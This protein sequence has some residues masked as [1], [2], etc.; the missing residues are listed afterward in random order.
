METFSKVF[1]VPLHNS[2]LQGMQPTN[3]VMKRTLQGGVVAEDLVVG[4]GPVAKQGSS[5]SVC[6]I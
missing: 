5:V 3:G 4:N 1:C 2:T 6:P